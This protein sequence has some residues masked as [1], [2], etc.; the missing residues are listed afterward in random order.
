MFVNGSPLKPL[1]QMI[2]NLVGSIYG[3]SSIKST[4]FVP[5]PLTN[6][7]ANQKKELSVVAMFV[8]RLGQN[9]QS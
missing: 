7:A 3:Q 9:E 8:N 2:R 6:M 5:I 4:H 1:G